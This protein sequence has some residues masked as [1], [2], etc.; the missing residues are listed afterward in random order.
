MASAARSADG[1][2]LAWSA[3]AAAAAPALAGFEASLADPGA[4]QRRLL[5]D[6]LARNANSE[7][8]RHYGFNALV[9]YEDYSRRVPICDWQT[10]LPWSERAR[11]I[12]APVLSEETPSFYERTSGSSANAKDVPYTASLLRE[13]QRALVVWL[14]KLYEQWPDVAG[15]SYWALSP[16]AASAGRAPNGIAIGSASDADYLMG[17]AAQGLLPT[18]LDTSAA[19]RRLATWRAATLR[20]LIEARSLRMFSVWSP[21]FLTALLE[22][23][24]S[25][26]GR[27]ATLSWLRGALSS[28]RFG[29]LE[30][31]L[32]NGHFATLWPDLRVVSC[33]TDGPSRPY[34]RR[35]ETLFPQA[36]MLP[37]GLFATEGVV[38]LP[39]GMSGRC[40]LAIESHVL[41][42][43]DDA[44]E[45]RL[46]DELENGGRYRPLLTTSGGLY[47]YS[48]G[49]I[50]EVDGFEKKTP[51]VRFLGR[52][53]NRSDLTGEKLDETLAAR[54]C[55]AA[56]ARGATTMLLPMPDA[57]PPA[58]LLLLQAPA[59]EERCA[60]DVERAL[61]KVF[62]Y[63]QARTTG[64]L[65]PLRAAAVDNLAGVLQRAWETL[66]RRAGDAKPATLIASLPLARAM[67][68]EVGA[69]DAIMGATHLGK[70]AAP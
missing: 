45:V 36:R 25:E 10:L 37:K 61:L 34:A 70:E 28:P 54:A 32:G 65:A 26:G 56:A 64:Q 51:C 20:M 53:D 30:R 58:Y 19:L 8:G 31:A 63:R 66:G 22:P 47:R 27:D 21:T 67:L 23:L 7:Y 68:C 4:V 1:H 14:A 49:D 43:V 11:D 24:L 6:I 39:W 55:Q 3:F 29:E 50:V 33:W 41:E 38:S 59:D 42:F 12:R 62:H 18:V 16:V 13:F 46:A 60:A 17:S 5:R 69:A 40:P 44:G 57:N 35:L 52:A 2:S 48:L 9:S 15:T